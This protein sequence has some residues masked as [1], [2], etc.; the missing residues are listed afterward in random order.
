VARATSA[1]PTYFEA[2]RAGEMSLVDGGVFAVNPAMCA[3]AEVLRW[4]PGAEVHLLSLGTGQRTRKRDWDEIKD[5]G[6][7]EWARP[8]LDVVFD[9]SSDAV[10]YQ[11]SQALPEER[12][13]RL[14]IELQGA[15]DHLDDAS[16]DNL[17]ALRERAQELIS[18]SGDQLDAAV[19]AFR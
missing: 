7:A 3:F 16:E 15:S 13:W 1:A 18:Q 11:L 10:D 14:Q 4:S 9:G 17:A 6:L 5:W 2:L 19:A 8:L 12:Y